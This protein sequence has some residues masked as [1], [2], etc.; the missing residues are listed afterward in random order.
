MDKQ[1]SDYRVM[2]AIPCINTVNTSLFNS[3]MHLKNNGNTCLAIETNSLVYNARNNLTIKAMDVNADYVLWIDSDMVFEQDTLIRLLT[4]ALEND[5]DFVTAL[6][7]K[8]ILPTQP[9]I[10]K[11]LY[12]SQDKMGE[13]DSRA[14]LYTDYP[15]DQVFEVECAGLGCALVKV[16]AIAEAAGACRMSPFQPLPGLSEDFSFCFRLKQIG[17]KMYCDSRVKVGHI[18]TMIFN[19][20]TWLEQEKKKGGDK[21]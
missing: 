2:I 11:S 4:D 1:L 6:Y 13:V 15:K 5:A 8:R 3:V 20:D 18:G 9:V 7:F 12:W 17:K 16:S 19:E 14:D 10:G 21:E